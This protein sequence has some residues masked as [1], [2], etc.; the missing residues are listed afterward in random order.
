MKR[1]IGLVLAASVLAMLGGCVYGPGYYQ[2]P[3]VAYDDGYYDSG[4][5]PAYAGYD[6]GYPYYSGYPYYG[7]GYGP[8]IGLGFSGSY[9][10][11]GHHSYHHRS[12]GTTTHTY[13][14]GH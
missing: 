4:Y 11:G 8:V 3:G 10:F 12:G 13:H 2:R 7:Y 9:F 14:H 1:L 6:Y 5:A